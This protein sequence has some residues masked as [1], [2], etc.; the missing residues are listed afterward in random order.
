MTH[1]TVH[2]TEVGLF[3]LKPTRIKGTYS[4][5]TIKILSE[6]MPFFKTIC[7]TDSTVVLKNGCS[8]LFNLDNYTIK[9]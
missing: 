1:T 8:L 9:L 6:K 5:Q 2:Q 7:K 3:L 4:S